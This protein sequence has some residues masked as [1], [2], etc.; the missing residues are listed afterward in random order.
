MKSSKKTNFEELFI[1]NMK[2]RLCDYIK[3]N[4]ENPKLF[5]TIVCRYIN[6]NLREASSYP[7]ALKELE[8]LAAFFEEIKLTP[9]PDMWELVL[10][11]NSLLNSLLKIVVETNNAPQKNNKSSDKLKNSVILSLVDCYCLSHGIKMDTIQENEDFR[12]K[13]VVPELDDKTDLLRT[14]ILSLD[15][16]LLTPEEEKELAYMLRD[17]NQEARKILIEKNLRLVI[18]IAK[19]YLDCGL[20]FMD[21]IQEGNI[22]LMKA[23]DHFDVEKG[24]RL[25]SYAVPSIHQAIRRALSN[26]AKNIRISVYFGQKIDKY[27]K[28]QAILQEKL[29]REPTLDEI[30]QKLEISLDEAAKLHMLQSDTISMQNFVDGQGDSTLEDFVSI[31][32]EGMEDKLITATLQNEVTQLLEN[33]NLNNKEREIIRLKYGF[34][35]DDPLSAY[36]I[37]DMLHLSGQRVYQI[38]AGAIKKLRRLK[39][40]DRLAFYLDNP[41]R[42]VENIKI[43]RTLYQKPNVNKK[44]LD[45]LEKITDEKL[46]GVLSIKESTEKL[47][48]ISQLFKFYSEEELNFIA[49]HL[50]QEEKESL[51][52]NYNINLLEEKVNSSTEYKN[53]SCCKDKEKQK[54]KTLS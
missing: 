22:G 24:Y 4:M 17:G 5:L 42:A 31:P 33:S 45:T 25:S 52:L 23:I 29:N 43:C 51:L 50:T 53:H 6:K 41:E 38:E 13:E 30:A 32:E 36:Q 54:K 2:K 7:A 35:G 27:R 46:N 40:I 37:G 20:S 14:Y 3:T 48:L 18:S 16:V 12:E 28:A 44:T 15:K 26:K 9:A 47:K 19:H 49:S 8:K 11:C 21:L 34:G 39:N 1:A 10:E